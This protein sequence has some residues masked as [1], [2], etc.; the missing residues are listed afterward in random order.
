VATV[1]EPADEVTD[2]AAGLVRPRDERLA[3][4]GVLTRVLKRPE[5]GALVAAIV[6]A[7]YFSVISSSFGSLAGVANYTDVASTLGIMSVAVSL[8]MIGGEFDLS[9][10]VMTGTTGLLVGL[11]TVEWGVPLALAIPLTF[12]FAALVGLVNGLIVVKTALP[13][14]IVTLGTFFALRGVNLGFTKQ[15]TGQ[16]RISGIDDEAGFEVIRKVVGSTFWNDFRT[17]VLWWLAFTAL[18]A[19]ILAR[20]KW[21]N[22]IFAVGGDANAAR[23]VGVPVNRTKIALFITTATAAA[24]VGILTAVR[25]R[26]TQASEGIGEEFEYIIAAVV[27]GTLLKGGYGS[28]VG[29]SIGALIM[30]MSFIGI[31]AAGWNSDWRWLFIGVILLLAVFMNQFIRLRAERARS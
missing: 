7:V 17:S 25:L 28:A 4:V 24:F 13:S 15:V 23:N 14:F 5:L 12:A 2:G 26:S 8:L 31:P 29:A 10:G 21:G 16:V 19:W 1:T 9:A 30:G 6:I 27:G 3:E 20:T 11:L 18:A 22:W